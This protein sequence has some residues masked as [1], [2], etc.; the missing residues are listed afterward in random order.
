MPSPNCGISMPE[1]NLSLGTAILINLKL[2]QAKNEHKPCD[3]LIVHDLRILYTHRVYSLAMHAVDYD[4][5]MS[6]STAHC[7]IYFKIT[8]ALSDDYSDIST[9]MSGEFRGTL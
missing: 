1:F 9:V 3:Y 7:S 6:D 8:P 4:N 2:L 5:R